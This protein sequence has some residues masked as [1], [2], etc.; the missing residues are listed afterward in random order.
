MKMAY[1]DV[2]AAQPNGKTVLLLHGKNFF[3]AYWA[4]LIQDLSAHGFRVIVPDQVGFGKS[5][6]P[7]TIQYSLHFL[8]NNTRILLDHLKISKTA[9]LGHSMGGMLASRFALMYPDITEKLIL[10]NPI[11]LED[12]KTKVPYQTVEQLYEEAFRITHVQL[13]DYQKNNYYHGTWKEEYDRWVDPIFRM[14]L[15]RDYPRL[16]RISALT[17]EMIYTQ[18]VCYEWGNLRMPTLLIIGQ[19]DR[20]AIGKNLVPEEVKKSLGNYPELGRITEKA[21]PHAELVELPNTG[22][23]PHVESYGEFLRALLPFLEKDEHE[24]VRGHS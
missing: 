9:V 4:Q 7:A 11:G 5:S 8:A 15:S 6:K 1:M 18:P 12:Y 21:I 24:A 10:E 19:L 13:R 17:S 14:T 16:A 22:H 3:G 23:I 2:S 20:T